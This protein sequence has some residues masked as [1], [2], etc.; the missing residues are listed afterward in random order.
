MPAAISTFRAAVAKR[1]LASD[2]GTRQ[3][4][5]HLLGS[6]DQGFADFKETFPKAVGDIQQ[7]L[8]EAREKVKQTQQ[9]LAGV[10]E[11]LA[12]QEAAAAAAAAA[13]PPAQPAVAIPAPPPLP[14]MAPVNL[15]VGLRLRDELL[16][17]FGSSPVYAHDVGDE[18]SVAERWARPEADEWPE[19]LRTPTFKK[20]GE[21]KQPKPPPKPASDDDSIGK[22]WGDESE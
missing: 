21:K 11:N 17:R 9:T 13:A 1:D 16:K 6:L 22:S 3:Q 20:P 18:G 14:T 8:D 15:Q 4:L 19:E 5:D 10:K 7:Q 2:A 12:R